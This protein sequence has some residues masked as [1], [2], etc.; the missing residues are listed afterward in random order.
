MQ[1]FPLLYALIPLIAGIIL[2]EYWSHPSLTISIIGIVLTIGA[3]LLG[4]ALNWWQSR[5]GD[6]IFKVVLFLCFASTGSA[7]HFM[8]QP[9]FMPDHYSNQLSPIA[10]KHHQRTLALICLK[11]D[12]CPSSKAMRCRGE[13]IAVG[14]KGADS[15][16]WVGTHGLAMFFF[17][18]DG[19][20]TLLH[21]GDTLLANA[22]FQVPS[23]SIGV[24][25][26]DYRGY[27]RHKKILH[28]S[29]LEPAHYKRFERRKDSG[30]ASFGLLRHRLL[31]TFTQSSL[32]PSQQA[33]A[34][35]ILL[36]YRSNLDPTTQQQFRDAGVTHLLCVSG[37]HVGIMAAIIGMLLFWIGGTPALSALRA[38]LQIAGIWC[39]VMLS[40]QSPATIR[41]ALM[42]TI[43]L[44]GRHFF[45]RPSSLNALA[46]SALILLVCN[47]MTLFDIGFQLSYAAVLG[48]LTLMPPM[49]RIF[50]N[51]ERPQRWWYRGLRGL[52]SLICLSTAAQLATLPFILYYF[53]Q[54]PLYFLIPNV[55]IV[56]L[57]GFLL[58]SLLLM[59]V[60]SWWPWAFSV[61]GSLV[62]MELRGID[63]ITRW[64]A[65]LPHSTLTFPHF[66]LSMALTVG[67]CI[68]TLMVMGQTSNE[69]I[70]QSRYHIAD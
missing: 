21:Q 64:S 4:M 35:A 11:E 29:F 27:L 23:D 61:M 16:I 5:Y 45:H 12:P 60:M 26:F 6:W 59:V 62:G 66:T 30:K 14:H 56:P 3:T 33:I 63:A 37:L 10:T 8:S 47:P 9:G 46:A 18:D 17:P 50:V 48:I 38:L 68:L 32:T 51:R 39:F 13:V 31:V 20:T 25:G 70:Q 41:A 24:D 67:V 7:L 2:T 49:Q 55:T 57:T 44:I 65:A 36:G 69:Q 28:T 22:C 52:W 42:F 1:K 34:Q 43:I 58:G 15:I 53:H 19:N 54:F 40:G